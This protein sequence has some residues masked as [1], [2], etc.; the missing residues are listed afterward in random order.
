MVVPP[1]VQ[2]QFT[3]MKNEYNQLAVRI[4]ELDTERSEYEYVGTLIYMF[5]NITFLP[6]AL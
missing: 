3:T 5:M 6:S 1:E 4:N 2:Q